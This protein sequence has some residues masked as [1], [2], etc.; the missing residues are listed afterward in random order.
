MQK[1]SALLQGLKRVTF[2]AVTPRST[3]AH[4]AQC[5][6]TPL[7]LHGQA[8]LKW[9]NTIIMPLL[10]FLCLSYQVNKIK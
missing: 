4:T 3:A 5:Q 2:T 6:Q 9:T 8:A 7:I 1:T 10:L